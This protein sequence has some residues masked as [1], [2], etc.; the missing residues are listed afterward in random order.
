[1]Q[2]KVI[3]IARLGIS[4]TFIGHGLLALSIKKSWIPLL[5]FLGFSTSQAETLL[6][7]IGI[8]DIIVAVSLLFCTNKKLIIWTLLWTLSTA[9][10]RP[11][12]GESILEF[13]E[14]ASNWCLPLI[15]LLLI[16][17]HPTIFG[18]LKK[19]D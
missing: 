11:I 7:I 15:L 10:L 3:N 4:L 9:A 2:Q 5:V 12:S 16:D 19:E 6:P 14:R 1:M 8:I 17:G 13:I 18:F